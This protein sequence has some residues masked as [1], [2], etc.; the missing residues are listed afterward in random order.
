[1]ERDREDE[2]CFTPSP[3]HAM[4]MR[5]YTHTHSRYTHMSHT[6]WQVKGKGAIRDSGVRGYLSDA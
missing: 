6:E 1:M 5:R 2:E 4:G 3:P